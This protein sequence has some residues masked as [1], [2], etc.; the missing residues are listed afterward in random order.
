MFLF[1]YDKDFNVLGETKIDGLDQVFTL[2]SGKKV[3]STP[4]SM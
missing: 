4:M 2:T 1:A 3:S